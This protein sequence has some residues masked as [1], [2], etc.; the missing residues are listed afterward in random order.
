MS[1]KLSIEL[2]KRFD[3]DFDSR[4]PEEQRLKVDELEHSSEVRYTLYQEANDAF[5][6]VMND[7]NTGF[8]DWCKAGIERVKAEWKYGA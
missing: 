5:E 8:I 7:K 1:V 4:S 2:V 6:S 3:P